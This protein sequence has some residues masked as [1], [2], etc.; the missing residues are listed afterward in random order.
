MSD[1]SKDLDKEKKK[2]SGAEFK[3]RRLAREAEDA[4][5]ANVMRQ[6][7]ESCMR[8]ASA[9]TH[10]QVADIDGHDLYLEFPVVAI[11]VKNQNIRHAID[12][13]NL[14]KTNKMENLVPNIVIAYRIML[15]TPV[16][17]ASGERSF[18]KL[19][20]IKNYLRNS[21]H[22]DRLNNLAIISIENNVA[23]SIDYNDVIEE[24]AASK[25]RKGKLN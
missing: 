15:S 22:Q 11:L 21:M 9:L 17:V 25:A 12:I 8:L 6:F 16:S 2:P 23:K 19:K 13:L 4:K 10:N 18:S 7:F 5:H 24:F 1:D 3:K 14:I 20:I